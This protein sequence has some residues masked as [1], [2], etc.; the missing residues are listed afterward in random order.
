ME[1]IT[2][3]GESY[4][5]C[6]CVCDLEASIMMRPWPHYGLIRHGKIGRSR[7]EA[8]HSPPRTLRFRM[9]GNVPPLPL[10][11][12]WRAQRRRDLS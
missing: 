10:L 5:M 6:A 4:L 11:P 9:N 8:H 7:L 2:R 3:P 1:L 12:T